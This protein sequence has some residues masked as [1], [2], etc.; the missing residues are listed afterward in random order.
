M[1]TVYGLTGQIFNG[2][3]ESLN[4]VNELSRL[5]AARPPVAR[6]DESWVDPALFPPPAHPAVR[7]YRAML[8]EELER[9]PLIHAAQVMSRPAITVA[10]QAPIKDAWRTLR[11]H[12]IRQA[13]V[14]D[15]ELRLVGLVSERDLLTAVDIENGGRLV[16]DT[17][18]RTDA[19]MTT[20]VVASH[21]I[22]DIRRIAAAMVETGV[23][24]V[25]VVGEHGQLLGFVSRGDVLRAVVRDPPLSLWR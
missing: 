15:A 23:G 18:R 2:P 24:G 20:P 17:L 5:A 6:E 21:P 25:P 19:V 7:S 16:G 11:H 3:L 12:R 8:P 10:A 4:R 14:L 9:G 13:P 22:T 1:F